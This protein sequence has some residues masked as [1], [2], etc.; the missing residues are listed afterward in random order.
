MAAR[1][2][3]FSARQIDRPAF[4]RCT[5][6]AVPETPHST[7]V[8]SFV[9]GPVPTSFRYDALADRCAGRAHHEAGPIPS[10]PP[11]STAMATELAP[12]TNLNE[13]WSICSRPLPPRARGP[14]PAGELRFRPPPSGCS[15]QIFVRPS[16]AAPFAASVQSIACREGR[17]SLGR[18]PDCVAAQ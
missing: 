18:G 11:D 4:S 15:S 16:L 17:H 3:R 14:F 1:C 13:P 2:H 6:L 9:S 12:R 5:G 7:S 10:T 8:R